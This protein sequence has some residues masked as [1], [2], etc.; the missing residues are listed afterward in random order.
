MNQIPLQCF[1]TAKIAKGAKGA[2]RAVIGHGALVN[3]AGL[4]KR[5]DDE[6]SSE[7]GFRG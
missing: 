3:G 1:F 6:A 4:M 5:L 7:R 2:L